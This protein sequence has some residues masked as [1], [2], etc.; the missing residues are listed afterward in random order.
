MLYMDCTQAEAEDIV[1]YTK[2]VARAFERLERFMVW[3]IGFGS[4]QD[5]GID[6]PEMVIWMDPLVYHLQG[7]WQ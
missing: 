5:E 1:E 7:G 2:D 4:N 6:V 3:T